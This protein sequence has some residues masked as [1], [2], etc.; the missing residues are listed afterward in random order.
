M[1]YLWRLSQTLQ[2]LVV[3]FSSNLID[4]SAIRP[5]FTIDSILSDSF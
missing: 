3:P 2:H 5:G 1:L 4:V